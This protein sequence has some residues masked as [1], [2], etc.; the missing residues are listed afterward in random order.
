MTSDTWVAL[1]MA[2][3]LLLP[4]VLLAVVFLGDR[5]LRH[6][7]YR[8][9]RWQLYEWQRSHPAAFT[10]V[11]GLIAA[12]ALVYFA[13]ESDWLM[14]AVYAIQL[15]GTYLTSSHAAPPFSDP[16]DEGRRLT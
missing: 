15:V 5:L 12:P 2:G 8:A 1:L 14:I 16:I 9:L 13:A 3:A 11:A 7:R 4:A 6:P 10:A